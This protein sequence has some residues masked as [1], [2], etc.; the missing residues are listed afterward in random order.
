MTSHI[1]GQCIHK[2]HYILYKTA[3]YIGPPTDVSFGSGG[4]STPCVGRWRMPRGSP[5]TMENCWA[6]ETQV[7]SYQ[8]RLGGHLEVCLP[9]QYAIQVS[10]GCSEDYVPHSHYDV[11]VCGGQME[12]KE[13]QNTFSFMKGGITGDVKVKYRLPTTWDHGEV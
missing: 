10:W 1:T 11:Q 4:E 13:K 8:N 2:K 7:P 5:A 9:S 12:E 3:H 6:L